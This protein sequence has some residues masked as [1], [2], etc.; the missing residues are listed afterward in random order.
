[1]GEKEV[2]PPA[3]AKKDPRLLPVQSFLRPSPPPAASSLT[4]EDAQGLL[5]HRLCL[6]CDLASGTR[7][8]LGTGRNPVDDWPSSSSTLQPPPPL[9]AAWSL[10]HPG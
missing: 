10:S 1:M 3:D 4:L 9:D 5:W 2:A 6:L 7:I 8:H